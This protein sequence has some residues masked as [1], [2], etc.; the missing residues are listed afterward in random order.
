MK[1]RFSTF[2]LSA[3]VATCAYADLSEKP[4]VIV[5]IADDLGYADV[6][7]QEIVADGVCTPNLD[8]LAK[9]G[10]IFRNAYAASAVCSNSRLSISTGRY[11]QRWGAYYYGE[12]GL[13]ETESTIAEM[14]LKAGYRTMKVGKTHLNGGDKEAPTKHGFEQS[15]GFVHHSWNHHLLSQ[16]D[17]DA[18][19]RK[20]AGSAKLANACPFGP[21]TRNDE[22][23]ESFENTTTTEVFGNESIRFIN[24]ESE[25]PFYLQL[26]F[27]AVHTP[28]IQPPAQLAKKYGIPLRAFDRNAEVWEYPLWDPIKEPKFGEWYH[29]TCHL[30]VADPY[31]RKIYLAHLE[32]MDSVI[33]KI[34]ETLEKNG[35]DENTIIFFT[36]DNGG[37]DQSYANNGEL[38][39]YKY[40]LM[41]GGIS[42]P[43]LMSWPNR[44]PQNKKID[45]LVTHLDIFASLSEITEIAPKNPLDGKSLLP[46]IDGK[47][48]ELHS[49]PVFWD[50]GKKQVSWITRQGDW[51]LLFRKAPRTYRAYE[52]DEN[53]LVKPEFR[54]V[55]LVT[56][57]QLYNLAEDPGEKTNLANKFPERVEQM[58]KMHAEWRAQMIDPIN[59]SNAK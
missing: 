55:P 11:A 14:M 36:S 9:S 1:S 34:T 56:G 43:M 51:K 53:G 38:N 58:K 52:L 44:L 23:K 37:S 20:K 27:N 18:Y 5:I 47:V 54:A 6:G 28:L 12:G 26:E 59:M 2:L 8:K 40:T 7:F 33:G 49:E 22:T 46:L 31:G 17:M 48:E 25:K 29:D 15:L 30:R 32:L 41:E 50:I 3:L 13:P 42:V 10:V 35:M 4:N 39:S 24:E 57:L 16:K 21:M 19:N 45:S